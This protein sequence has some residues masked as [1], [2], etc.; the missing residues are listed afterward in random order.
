MAKRQLKRNFFQRLLGKPATQL[1]RDPECWNYANGTITINLARASE[2][3]E[4]SGALRLEGKGLSKHILVVRG[5]DNRFYA[6]H[7]RC[8]HGGRRVDPDPEHAC[9]QCCSIGKSGFAY[10]GAK[11]AG[12]AKGPLTVYPVRQENDTLLVTVS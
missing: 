6:V 11:T 10:D 9:L 2:L 5:E 1:P 3:A 7:N 8:T 4:P 12:P